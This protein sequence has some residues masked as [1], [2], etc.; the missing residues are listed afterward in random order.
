[1]WSFRSGAHSAMTDSCS[2]KCRMSFTKTKELVR[3]VWKRH[4]DAG[5]VEDKANAAA[6][7]DELRAG[8]PILVAV[9][10][11]GSKL[12]GSMAVQPIAEGSC[13]WIQV[14]WTDTRK[15]EWLKDVA[16]KSFRCLRWP[17][18]PKQVQIAPF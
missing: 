4:G 2:R 6:I 12:A 8:I 9:E 18:A 16:G 13:V 17:K 1:M 14:P 3:E 10:P 15:V 7:M 11:L 5:L